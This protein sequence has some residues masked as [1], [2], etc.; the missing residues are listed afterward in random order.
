MLPKGTGLGHGVDAGRCR[1]ALESAGRR[2][3]PAACCSS[4]AGCPRSR[5]VAG[6]QAAR[7]NETG[8]SA[9]L[10]PRAQGKAAKVCFQ[11][12]P[13]CAFFCSDRGKKLGSLFPPCFGG[14]GLNPAGRH[15]R[16]AFFR[17]ADKE[18]AAP[19]RLRSLRAP[20]ARAGKGSTMRPSLPAAE[21][22]RGA[23]T[24]AVFRA[25]DSA[26]TSCAS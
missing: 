17:R 4:D 19:P 24:C 3:F 6:T 7:A 20:S 2:C 14:L 8:L 25:A 11:A 5:G 21:L 16:V 9:D 26:E 10:L 23:A 22:R 12:V 15:R 13:G 1:A 18:A